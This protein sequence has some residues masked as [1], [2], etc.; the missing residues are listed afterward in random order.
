VNNLYV[1]QLNHGEDAMAAL[2]AIAPGTV[3]EIHLAGHLVTPDAVVDHHGAVVADPVWRLYE[4]ALSRFGA[5]PTLIEW[6]TD[7]P[8]L[9]VLLGEAAKA[10]AIAV[11]FP[12]PGKA[13]LGI[14]SRSGQSLPMVCDALAAQQQAFSD[15]LFAPAAEA[16]LKLRHGER[17]GLYRG[18]LASTWTKA[19]AAAYPVIAQLVGEE[20]FA[21]L[22]REY[23]RAHPSDSG[24]LN[25]FGARFE[26][27]LRCFE[28][29]KDLPY[30]PDMARLEWQLHGT[31]P[32][33][34]CRTSTRKRWRTKASAGSLPPSFSSRRGQSC[35]S[36]W[37]IKA[38][39]S[40]R[41]WTSQAARCSVALNGQPRLRSCKRRNTQRCRH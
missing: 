13:D 29:V 16:S 37:P 33:C 39:H 15:A 10:A 12:P 4:A 9:E 19:L 24:D 28:H 17:F 11:N 1:N 2:R 27:F 35:P 7:I 5:V 22:A 40:R 25:R 38:C 26:P 23:G 32:R 36:G 30:L 18:N 6:D 14:A 34:K 21:A 3:G 41:R 31:S 8:P 20:F